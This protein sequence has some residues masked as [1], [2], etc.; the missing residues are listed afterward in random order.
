MLCLDSC[1]YK[2]AVKKSFPP[3]NAV[4]STFYT[5]NKSTTSLRSVDGV[6][7]NTAEGD[8]ECWRP[9]RDIGSLARTVNMY[10]LEIMQLDLTHNIALGN[11]ASLT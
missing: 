1:Y 8:D 9:N 2:V 4:C 7:E 6:F 3:S 5:I 11:V 10:S